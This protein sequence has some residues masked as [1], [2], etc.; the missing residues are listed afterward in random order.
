MSTKTTQLSASVRAF[1]PRRVSSSTFVLSCPAMNT[2][3][4]STLARIAEPR[5]E[6]KIVTATTTSS[7]T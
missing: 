5:V 3:M 2:Q 1:C 4:P 7:C 6:K